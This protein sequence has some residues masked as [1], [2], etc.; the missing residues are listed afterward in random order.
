MS[1]YLEISWS[2][3]QAPATLE[4]KGEILDK[5][6]VLHINNVVVWSQRIT[7]GSINDCLGISLNRWSI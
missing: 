2:L 6:Y 7:D 4:M 3:Y 1:V 5:F